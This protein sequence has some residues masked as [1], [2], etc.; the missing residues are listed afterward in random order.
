[1]H[2]IFYEL[3]TMIRSIHN[4]NKQGERGFPCL[5]SLEIWK[6]LEGEPFINSLLL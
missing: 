6:K 3:T 4:Y 2:N 1:M 5:N